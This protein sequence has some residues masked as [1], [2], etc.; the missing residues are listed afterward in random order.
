MAIPPSRLADLRFRLVDQDPHA[1]ARVVS[2]LHAA[3]IRPHALHYDRG[4]LHLVVE[5]RDEERLRRRLARMV[6]VAH[7]HS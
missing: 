5:A 6:S 7:V 2:G 1:L 4:Y 3:G